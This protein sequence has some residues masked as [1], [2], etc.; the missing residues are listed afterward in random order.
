MPFALN[1][2]VIP[3]TFASVKKEQK[4]DAKRTA[5]EIMPCIRLFRLNKLD[6]GKIYKDFMSSGKHTTWDFYEYLYELATQLSI[7][8]TMSQAV[9]KDTFYQ[10]L[11]I[12]GSPENIKTVRQYTHRS[13]LPEY[14]K[15]LGLEVRSKI[16]T[17]PSLLNIFPNTNTKQFSRTYTEDGVCWTYYLLDL[18][19][20]PADYFDRLNQSSYNFH[21]Q[22]TLAAQ[23]YM[24]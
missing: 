13:G 6:L 7:N 21:M 20:L 19:E 5:Q 23:R 14:S 3:Q 10:V 15:K 12:R 24:F 4:V 11:Q 1:A 17:G 18:V 16:L 9:R 22:N 8:A 2:K